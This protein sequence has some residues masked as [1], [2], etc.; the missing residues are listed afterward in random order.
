MNIYTTTEKEK[1][2]R[3]RLPPKHKKFLAEALKYYAKNPTW[4]EFG[5]FWLTKGKELWKGLEGKEIVKLP[6]FKI[7]Q[8]LEI[9]LGIKQGYTRERDYLDDLEDM[10]RKEFGSKYK[11]CRATGIDQGFLSNVLKKR[12]NFS[13]SKL[14]VALN[15]VGYKL[16]IQ[17]EEVSQ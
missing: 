15:K 12:K 3:D 8:D 10:I 1:F 13:I 2:D 5:Q 4:D 9:R 11:F 14:Q 7:C 17:K 6:I 16:T